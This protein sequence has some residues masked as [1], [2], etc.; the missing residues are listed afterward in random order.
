MVVTDK[1]AM[2]R[3]AQ[4]SLE[5]EKPHAH[6][7]GNAQRRTDPDLHAR[8]RQLHRTQYQ[9]QF[10][11]FAHHHQKHKCG[12]T[13]TGCASGLPGIGF[14][15]L[16]DFLLQVT[17]H[18]VHPDNHGDHQRRGHQHQQP[19]EAILA[20]APSLQQ[21]GRANR[22]G[23]GGD[24]AGPSVGYECA[25]TSAVQVD[26]DDADDKRGFHTFTESDQQSR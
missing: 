22:G 15:A 13:P 2:K 18:L 19:F 9:N 23:G 11:A 26:E 5:E 8:A 7:H 10:R 24:D 17:R 6:S 4:R 12:D 14:D 20:D 16:L 3:Y 21:N 1:E 25:P